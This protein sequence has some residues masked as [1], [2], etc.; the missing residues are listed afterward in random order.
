MAINRVSIVGM[1]SLGLIF[2][3]ILVDN[4]GRDNVEF[5]MGEDR[6]KRY[7][8]I[9]RTINGNKY[10]F[11]L[12]PDT[13]EGKYADL[14]IFAVKSTDLKD[15]IKIARNK[16]S[17]D[18]IIISL[19]NGITSEQILGD[20]FGEEKVLYTIAEAM[21]PIRDGYNLRY[22][23]PGY[24]NI[25]IDTEEKGKKEKLADLLEFFEKTS[26]PYKFEKDVKQ[27]LWS[28]FMLN[29]GVNQATMIYEGTYKTIQTPGPARKLMVDA[30][31]EVINLAEKE[32]IK[33]TEE[34]LTFYVSIIDTLN[35]ES[36]PSMRYD[37]LHKKKS[38]VEIFSGTVIKLGD[39]H[40]V[41]TPINQY[42]YDA[43]LEIESKY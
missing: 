32:N 8:G 10:D 9:E 21:D 42:I 24:V 35:P 19:L 39:K 41:P 28:K 13:Q 38:E 22:T 4:M 18:T 34:D 29:V 16:I 37:G 17:D 33:V 15:A 2:G 1:G 43:I 25:G 12:V 20:A 23:K 5:I 31:K 30:M 14:L 36:M 3:G 27:R 7:S 26:F 40:G 6:L 11:Q